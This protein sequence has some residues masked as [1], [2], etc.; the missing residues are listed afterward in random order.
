MLI[1]ERLL[2]RRA[3]RVGLRRAVV[4]ERLSNEGIMQIRQKR[5]MSRGRT[6][7][8]AKSLGR[9]VRRRWKRGGSEGTGDGSALVMPAHHSARGVRRRPAPELDGEY[10][11]DVS[12]YCV[13]CARPSPMCDG[14]GKR[15]VALCGTAMKAHDHETSA[16]E[17]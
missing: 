17:K 11:C 3:E 2:T 16:R 15:L 4:G 13:S 12:L 8:G 7:C 6:D 9:C 5:Q 10:V 1:D 14:S